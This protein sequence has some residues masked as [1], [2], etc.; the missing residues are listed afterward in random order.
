MGEVD[1][2]ATD[3]SGRAMMK[4]SDMLPAKEDAKQAPV[5]VKLERINTDFA[6]NYPPTGEQ[7]DKWRAR[8][9]SAMATAST[10]FVDATLIQLQAAARLPMSGLSEIAVNAALSLIEN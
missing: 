3:E 8:L 1:C 2:A 7:H 10:E 4:G 6:R 9:K 5:R